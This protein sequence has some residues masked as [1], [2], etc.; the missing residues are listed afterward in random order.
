ME[1]ALAFPGCSMVTTGGHEL[2][3]LSPLRVT[4][5]SSLGNWPWFQ[6]LG[7]EYQVF[8]MS[9]LMPEKAL[10]VTPWLCDPRKSHSTSLGLHCHQ[11]NKMFELERL[12]VH[13]APRLCPLGLTCYVWEKCVH[14]GDLRV[15]SRIGGEDLGLPGRQGAR[16]S[17]SQSEDSKP[18]LQGQACAV[19]SV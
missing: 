17:T 19:P 12:V 14:C 6:I 8:S 10:P 5:V 11:Q 4:G 1:P 9:I 3:H 2:C 18:G 7:S 13:S 15:I 16:K